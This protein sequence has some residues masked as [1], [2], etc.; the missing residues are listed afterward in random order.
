MDAWELWIAMAREAS[1]TAQLADAAGRL[2]SAASRYYY[3]AYQT[4]T[5]LLLYQGLIPPSGVEAW[6][7][8]ITPTLLNEET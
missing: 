6:S 3:A 8:F 7:H 4:V 1:E 2:R 5:A